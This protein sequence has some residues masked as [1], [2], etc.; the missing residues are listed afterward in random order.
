M[1]GNRGEILE[2]QVPAASFD[3]LQQEGLRF[4]RGLKLANATATVRI[5][6][7]EPRGNQVGSVTLPVAEL[8]L[9]LARLP[10]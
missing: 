4:R 6:L 7:K 3:Q 10:R 2:V 8:P 1:I 5:V 9:A